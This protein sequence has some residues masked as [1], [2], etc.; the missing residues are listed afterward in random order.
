MKK[1]LYKKIGKIFEQIS[2]L[3]PQMEESHTSFCCKN[4]KGKTPWKSNLGEIP[5]PNVPSLILKLIEIA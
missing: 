3:T 5:Q 2:N 4:I 1:N